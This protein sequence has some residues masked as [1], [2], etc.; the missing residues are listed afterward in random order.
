M[1]TTLST[2]TLD[3]VHDLPVAEDTI[4]YER[5]NRLGLRWLNHL[6]ALF[7][8][9]SRRRLARAALHVDE[10]RH[11]E[12]EHS[13]LNDVD[14]RRHA[15]QLKGRARGGESLDRL[16]PELFGLVCIA[17]VRTLKLRPFDVQL[18][19]GFVLHKGALAELATGEGKTLCASLPASLN[20]LAGKGVHVTTVNDYLARRD[21]DWMRPVYEAVGLT[22]GCL[23]MQMGD[24]DRHRA[25]RCDITYGTASEF[26]FDFLRDRL[27]V[28]GS[29]GQEAPFWA[30]WT[31][32][33]AQTQAAL[34]PKVQRPHHFALVDEA[35]N[36]FVDEAKTP[37]IISA[38]TRQASAEEQVVYHWANKLAVAM[39]L[40]KHFTLDEKKQK[41]ELTEEGKQLA[42]Y[43]NP[44]VGPHSHAMDK[45]HEHIERAL[46]ANYRFRL[47][48]H[49]MIEKDKIVIIDD[50]T[51][52]RMPDRHWREGLHQAVEAK[53]GVPVTYAAD[54]A[55]QITFQSYFRLYK[56]LSGMT[57]TAAQNFWEIRR[58]YKIWVVCVPTNRPVIRE[59]WDDQ[60]YPTEEAKFDAVVNEVVRMRS[61]GRSVL[62]GTRSVERSERLS[63]RLAKLNIDHQ[64]LNARQ[65]EQEAKIVTD[66]GQ[67]GKVTI[68]TNMAGRG[69]DIKLGPGVAEAGGLHVLSTERNEARRIDRQL[70]GR[71]G[72][73]GDPGSCQFFVSLEDELLEA[74][75]PDRQAALQER[76]QKGGNIDWQSYR[77]LFNKAQSKVERRHYRQ[78]VDLMIYEKQR[79]EILK[80]LGADPYVD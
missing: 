21:A 73:Q 70:A 75:G 50:S 32:G 11:W 64:V 1:S 68:A 33:M 78:R 30:P 25:Y 18:A 69:T 53:E 43:S 44:P 15:L 37:L 10:V 12:K 26:G 17:S 36:I 63:R 51:G 74:L 24:A 34:D 14:L 60:V 79:Q 31:P 48:Q 6:K 27:K 41:I 3:A 4:T 67:A 22:V 45:L 8:T 46:H 49:Y 9:P 39:G 62:I 52:R 38:P 61:Q 2:A 57:G 16:L 23:Q 42:R 59:Q 76:G 54:H 56:K 80:D 77:P 28:S 47:D 58:V 7:G 13:R 55:A 66:A 5:S 35:D 19:A 65:H 20:A 72:R 71:S 40:N 29:K